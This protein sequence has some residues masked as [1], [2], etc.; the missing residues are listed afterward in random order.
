MISMESE[1]NTYAIHCPS[2][3]GQMYKIVTLQHFFLIWESSMA[4]NL[5]ISLTLE[6]LVAYVTSGLSGPR[7]SL[8]TFFWSSSSS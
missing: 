5:F 8:S 6:Y 4:I 2:K 3:V 1:A 7:H